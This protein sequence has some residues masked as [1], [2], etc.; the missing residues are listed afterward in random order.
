MCHIN[1]IGLEERY[2]EIHLAE[3][4]VPDLPVFASSCLIY[5]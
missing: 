3:S 2:Q 1:V 4:N 5:H